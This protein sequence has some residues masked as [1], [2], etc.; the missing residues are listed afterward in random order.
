MEEKDFDALAAEQANIDSLIGKG[1]DFTVRTSAIERLFGSGKEK[2]FTIHEPYTG[3]LDLLADEFLKMEIDEEALTENPIRQSNRIIK[4]SAEPMA[5]VIAV[6]VL[7]GRCWVE[8]TPYRGFV[9]RSLINRYTNYF[10]RRLKPSTLKQLALII[11]QIMNAGDFI[12]SIRWMSGAI[13]RTTKPKANLVEE[14]Q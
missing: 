5:R 3:T 4:R 12:N 2:T 7:N 13:P 11:R 9:N 10:L 8:L 6:A 14:K 1:M